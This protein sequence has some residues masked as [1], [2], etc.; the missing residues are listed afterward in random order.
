MPDV[1]V[2][3]GREGVGLEAIR[4]AWSARKPVVATH[5]AAAGRAEHEVDA[6]LVY[7]S[8]TAIAAAVVRLLGD[9]ELARKLGE[10]GHRRW[11][12]DSEIVLPAWTSTPPN[13]DP[14]L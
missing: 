8:E 1:V 3:P 12:T 10:A 4:A 7:P 14:E 5:E 13:P 9:P 6:L 11:P 2:V